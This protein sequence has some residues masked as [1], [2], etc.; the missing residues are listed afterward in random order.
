M[1]NSEICNIERNKNYMYEQR[2]TEALKTVIIAVFNSTASYPL[3]PIC[4]FSN[5]N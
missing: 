3:R 1:Q 2:E 4:L 5:I